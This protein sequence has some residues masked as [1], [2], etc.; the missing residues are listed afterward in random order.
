MQSGLWING[1]L[2][3]ISSVKKLS[4]FREEEKSKQLANNKQ[5]LSKIK[6]LPVTYLNSQ[7]N[8][9]VRR[10]VYC[11]MVTLIINVSAIYWNI[12]AVWSPKQPSL[13]ND[14]LNTQMSKWIISITSV[15]MAILVILIRKL[16]LKQ[17]KAGK[18]RRRYYMFVLIE[19]IILCL[20]VPPKCFG[21]WVS[22]QRDDLKNVYGIFKVYLLFELLKLNH[23][24]WLR[25]FEVASFQAKAPGLPVFIGNFF[26]CTTNDYDLTS[27]FLLATVTTVSLCSMAVYFLMRM[28]KGF[29]FTNAMD[30]ILSELVHVPRACSRAHPCDGYYGHQ[31]LGAIKVF[32]GTVYFIN[33]ALV[34]W[35]FGFRIAENSEM[36]DDLLNDVND[37]IRYYNMNAITIQVWWRAHLRRKKSGRIFYRRRICR[38]KLSTI[39][40]TN[41]TLTLKDLMAEMEKTWKDVQALRETNQKLVKSSKELRRLLLLFV[42]RRRAN[43]GVR[44]ARRTTTNLSEIAVTGIKI[45]TDEK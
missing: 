38:K 32:I 41:N 36:V 30:G 33:Q 31:R 2:G 20:H 29:D 35:T 23:P 13:W 19:S 12:T 7:A 27:I 15:T 11:L 3:R 25:R 1:R 10:Y 22:R 42:E 4:V 40:S 14:N 34:A 37:Y 5:R 24:L 17:L 39:P 44:S 8:V 18:Q 16:D 9:I 6:R 28:G 43:R 45:I 26:C 21:W